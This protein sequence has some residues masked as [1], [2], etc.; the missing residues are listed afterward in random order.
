MAVLAADCRAVIPDIRDL[1]GC[2]VSEKWCGGD[3]SLQSNFD[4]SGLERPVIG[5]LTYN[6]VHCRRCSRFRVWDGK[7]N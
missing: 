5:Q 4:H 3:V 7:E 6:W 2:R 1:P